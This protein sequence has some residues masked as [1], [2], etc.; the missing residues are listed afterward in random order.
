MTVEPLW[1]DLGTVV[2]FNHAVVEATGEPHGIRDLGLLASAVNRPAAL[3]HYAS[4][5]DLVVLAARL[6]MSIA[7]NHPFVQGN[8]R[9]ALIAAIAF[10]EANGCKVLDHEAEATEGLAELVEDAVISGDE[11]ALCDGLRAYVRGPTLLS[12]EV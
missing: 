12:D 5:H 9:T 7:A 10:I 4:E 2:D 1:L 11:H 6:L 3:W 8:K